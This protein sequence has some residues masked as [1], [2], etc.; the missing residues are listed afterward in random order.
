LYK[1]FEKANLDLYPQEFIERLK[2]AEN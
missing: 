2:K 1:V